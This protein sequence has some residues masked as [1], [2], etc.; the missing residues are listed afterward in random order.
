M[1]ASYVERAFRPGRRGEG[2]RRSTSRSPRARR[3]TIVTD[4][5][6]LAA[7]PAQPALQRVQV[8]RRGRGRRWRRPTDELDPEGGRTRVA[9]TVTDTGIGIA[10]GQAA[11]DLRGLPAGRRHDEPP[12]R[13]HRP[14][15]VD[16]PRDRAPARRRDPRSRRP[17]ARAARS[18]C[19]CPPTSAA[20]AASRTTGEPTAGARR[21]PRPSS[22]AIAAEPP[23]PSRRRRRRR[24]RADARRRAGRP[25]GARSPTTA[26]CSIARPPRVRRPA[27]AARLQGPAS[28]CARPTALGARAGVPARRRCCSASTPRSASCSSRLKHDPRTRHLP[29]LAR[30]PTER[31][32]HDALRAGA[33]ASSTPG[34]DDGARRRALAD[35]RRVRRPP[36]CATCSS[37][38]T[39]TTERSSDRRADRRRGRRG[40][41]RVASSEEALDRARRGRASTASCST[42]S[43][44][45]ASGFALLERVKADERHRDVAGD[46]PHRQGADPPRG[47]AAA[48]ATPSRSS[49][50]T[51]ARPSGC[52]TRRRCACTARPSRSLPD[53]DRRH[54]RAACATP[55]PCCTAARS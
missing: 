37:S 18:R 55:T 45:K 7:G 26:Y 35:A 48:S 47:D 19:C 32:R 15:P 10:A 43:C 46:H 44:P 16:Q 40:R 54:A 22:P 53:E 3:T 9:F 2:A 38:T 49:S 51:P 17:R 24:P 52:S 42:S 33:A 34:T 31:A 13:R 12:L 27:R 36:R 30:R 14:R 25:R 29:V 1:L 28:R 8:H 23:R 6:R 21:A 41:R 39:T 11:A 50:R 4:E 20:G 5:Q